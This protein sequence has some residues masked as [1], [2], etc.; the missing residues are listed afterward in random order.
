MSLIFRI[1]LIVV[2]LITVISILRKIRH[3]KVQIEHSVFWIIFSVLLL[4]MA[5]FPH[6]P[7]WL[8][9]KLGIASPANLVFL[10]IIFLLLVKLFHLTAEISSLEIK[11]KELAQQIALKK[12]E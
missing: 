8:S 6:I 2:A 3:E 10:A 5:V 7:I 11:L 1:L 4:V 9:R 12:E